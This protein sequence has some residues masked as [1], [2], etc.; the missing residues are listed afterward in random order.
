VAQIG[1]AVAGPD[2]GQDFAQATEMRLEDMERRQSLWRWVLIAAFALFV[3]ET[4]LSNWVSRRS[5]VP[6][7]ATG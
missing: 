1:T 4:L 5:G 2:S 3:I 7:V 6:G